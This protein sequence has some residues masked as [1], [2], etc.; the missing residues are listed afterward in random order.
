MKWGCRV[1]ARVYGAGFQ[2]TIEGNLGGYT[3]RISESPKPETPKGL[4]CGIRLLGFR[5]LVSPIAFRL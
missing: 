4:V 3:A 2:G 1:S 5:I